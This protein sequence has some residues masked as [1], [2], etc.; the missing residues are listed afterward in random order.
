MAT[1]FFTRT[2]A[3]ALVAGMTLAGCSSDESASQSQDAA[4]ESKDVTLIVH[5]SF[6]NEDFEKAASA[7]TGLNVKVVSAGDGGELSAKLVLSKGSPVADAFFGIDDVFASR[8]VNENVSV[9]V[10]PREKLGDRAM[11]LAKTVSE[12]DNDSAFPLLPI[13]QGATCLNIDPAWFAE[14]GI[15]PPKTYEDLTK[16]TYKGL[17]VLL[18]PTSSST[19]ASFLIG[20]VAKFGEDGFADYHKKL[21]AND[22][23]IVQGWEEAYNTHFTTSGGEYPIVMSYSSSPGYTVNEAGTETST[24]ALLDTCSSQVEYAGVLEGAK[25]VKGAEKVVN[26]MLSEEFQNTIADSMYVYPV[27]D[28]AA[29]PEAWEKFA[30]FPKNPH[31]LPASKI[32]EGREAW[33][34]AWSE[35]TS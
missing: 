8:I 30:P 6:P 12:A 10:T 24:A 23:R 3:L 14:K 7:A 27:N 28:K 22:A 13:T 26:Y 11:T 18:D 20:T 16:E 15:E 9:D 5:D 29:V 31:D 34:K 1:P 33:L 17:S 35:A 32:G 21:A 4:P 19:G 2:T 25:N